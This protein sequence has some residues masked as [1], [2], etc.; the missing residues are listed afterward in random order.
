MTI[1]LE[2][3]KVIPARKRIEQRTEN[4]EQ[5]KGVMELVYTI[6]EAAR[7][8]RVNPVTI[9]K[10]IQSGKLKAAQIGSKDWRISRF[11]LQAWFSSI[12]GGELFGGTQVNVRGHDK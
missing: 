10:A 9:R 11:D 1:N 12:G 3:L 6:T 5:E 4:R 2:Y 8:L 7:L